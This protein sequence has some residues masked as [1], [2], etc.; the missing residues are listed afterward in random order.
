MRTTLIA[1]TIF[2]VVNDHR[3]LA[4]LSSPGLLIAK[5][6][7]VLLQL[8][9]L[10]ALLQ[11]S[12]PTSY[13]FLC[14]V[15]AIAQPSSLHCATLPF[16]TRPE[17]TVS[18]QQLRIIAMVFADFILRRMLSFF[19]F[20]SFHSMLHCN[21]VHQLHIATYAYAA[22]YA[23]AQTLSL[24]CAIF[25]FFTRPEATVS[26]A[27]VAMVFANFILRLTLHCRL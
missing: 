18:Q 22:V 13:C 5:L 19:S 24:H 20:S 9:S 8:F 4:K 16:S 2:Q 3:K 26:F 17:A 1:G 10:N 21:G 15:S 6:P 11:W 12:S 25:T 27:T 7:S 14:F 23:I